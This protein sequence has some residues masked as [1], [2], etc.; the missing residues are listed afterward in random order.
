[1]ALQQHYK[2]FAQSG[3]RLL[4]SRITDAFG[5]VERA[6][7]A[8]LFD[9]QVYVD[10]VEKA[11]VRCLMLCEADASGD[12]VAFHGLPGESFEQR[13]GS[14]A[15]FFLK[16]KACVVTSRTLESLLYGELSSE[17]L[18][19]L[20]RLLAE[21]YVPVMVNPANQEGW[22]EVACKDI[23][24]KV[25][26][27]LADVTI[28]L[29]RT[30]GQTW[31]PLPP[32]SATA[33]LSADV[34]GATSRRQIG[35]GRKKE[36]VYLLETTLI[37]WTR[38]IR[39]ILRR[40]PETLLKQGYNPTPTAE[41]TFWRERASDLNAVFAQLQS[42]RVRG[43][44]AVLD[45]RR[46]PVGKS[47]R[48]LIQEVLT[49]RVE[50]IDNAKFVG[51][52]EGIFSE[53]HSAEF[54]ALPR[55]FPT[56]LYTILGIWK[57]S[58]HYN[59]HPR[60]IVL[61]N[62][63]NNE[64]I[65]KAREFAS[66]EAIFGMIDADDASLAVQK[67][68][69]I[70]RVCAAFKSTFF[71]FKSKCSE[72]CPGNA[73][74][75]P[76]NA[77][78][79]RLD[80]FVERCQD[81]LDLTQTIVQF[82]K[83]AQIEIGGTKGKTLTTSVRQI[84]ADFVDAVRAFEGAPYDI[85]DIGAKRF[86]DDFYA[87]RSR[88]KELERRLGSIITQAFDDAGTLFGQFK[89]LD[90]FESLL[91]REL[92]HDE[93]EKRHSAL[94]SSYGKDLTIVGELFSRE[95]GAFDVGA[96]TS[97]SAPIGVNLPPIAGALKWVRMLM[98]RI[99]EPMERLLQ[100]DSSIIEKEGARDVLKAFG[101]TLDR[102]Q[103]FELATMQQLN[104]VA[105]GR[106]LQKLRQP[107][108]KRNK[109]RLLT[110]NFDPALVRL[111]REVK[112]FQLE[113]LEVPHSARAIFGKVEV[114]RQQTG[115]LELIVNMYND[116]VSNMLPVERPLLHNAVREIDEQLQAGIDVL[117]W[118]S[119]GI[120]VFLSD[121]MT[122]VKSASDVLQQLKKNVVKIRT[123]LASWASEPLFVRNSKPTAWEDLK[124]DLNPRLIRRYG[125]IHKGGVR[126]HALM[127]E[128]N[129]ILRVSKGMPSWRAY[130][131]FV[132]RIVSDGLRDVAT[133]SLQYILGEIKAIKEGRKPPILEISLD[134]FGNT[135]NGIMFVPDLAAKADGTGLRDIVNEWIDGFLHVA[136][137]FPRIDEP[138][139]SV[140]A[141]SDILPEGCTVLG[142][143]TTHRIVRLA[144][145][146]SGH[147]A[148]YVKDLLSDESLHSLIGSITAE[149]DESDIACT[150]FV[151]KYRGYAYLWTTDLKTMFSEFLDDSAPLALEG[152]FVSG[153]QPQLDKFDEK[154]EYY[155][156]VQVR[157]AEL[158]TPSDVG[159]LR[160]NSQP[161]KQALN[162]CTTKWKFMF[163]NWLHNHVYDS[164]KELDAFRNFVKSGLKENPT[165]TTSLK[166][167]MTIIR[168]VRRRID[169]TQF[170]FAPLEN[171]VALLKKHG[172]VV[173]AKIGRVDV[174]E[175]LDRA[176]MK[177]ETTV[178][179]TFAKKE[180]ILPLQN[181][182]VSD[183]RSQLD[184]FAADVRSERSEFRARAPLSMAIVREVGQ[185]SST[186]GVIE[187]H[188]TAAFALLTNFDAVLSHAKEKSADLDNMC[189]L[190]EVPTQRLPELEQTAGE[191][192][193]L[194][195]V[196]TLYGE[197]AK[198]FTAWEKT[199]WGDVVT[200]SFLSK[201]QEFQE[202]L[203]AHASAAEGW[204]LYGEMNSVLEKMAIVFPLV[205]SLR[206]NAMRERHWKTLAIGCQAASL[207]TNDP[208]F[209]LR[210]LLNLQLH[211]FVDHVELVVQTATKE[212]KIEQT[213]NTI[214]A[215]WTSMTL[216]FS[217]YKD[218]GVK[219][220]SV[221]DFVLD[222]LEE[223]TAQLQMMMGMG[224]FVEYFRSRVVKWQRELSHVESVLRT[225]VQVTG[226]WQALEAIFL[227]SEEIRRQ[228]PDDASTFE[229]VHGDFASLMVQAALTPNVLKAC[230]NDELAHLL[231]AKL[232]PRLEQC[233][234]SLHH[235]L[236]HQRKKFPR[237]YFVANDALVHV[238]SNV[239]EPR[240]IV[241][242]CCECFNNTFSSIE[243]DELA[244]KQ[245]G[246]NAILSIASATETLA[247]GE[248][249]VIGADEP[250][251][252]WLARFEECITAT[253]KQQMT[254]AFKA[255][256]ELS[257]KQRFDWIFD[258]AAQI[259]LTTVETSWTEETELALINVASGSQ[260][261]MP[262]HLEK[263]QERLLEMVELA[264][265]DL[266]AAQ[267][268]T[269]VSLITADVHAR[270]VVAR[271]VE[272]EVQSKT[273][274]A[275]AQQLRF[276]WQAPTGSRKGDES[277][278]VNVQICDV[279]DQ[280]AA[281][282]DLQYLF[283][284]T[285]NNSRLVVTP[286]TERCYVT[287]TKAIS[288]NLGCMLSGPAGSGKT[289]TVK[290][291]ASALGRPMLT[292]N[293]SEQM[294]FTT[295]A[296]AF[297]GLVQNGA[298][299]CFDG[300]NRL[301]S[302]LLSVAAMQIKSVHNAIE[303]FA[304]PDARAKQYK[305]V[306]AGRPHSI[307]GE[308]ELMG[309]S[310]SLIPT[311]SF[312]ATMN[313]TYIGRT[314][315]LPASIK[316][317]FRPCGM[318]QPDILCICENMLMAQGFEEATALAV[319]FTMLYKL[320]DEMLSPQHHYDW[321]LRSAK[322]V[323]VIA[324]D[325]MRKSGGEGERLSEEAVLMRALRNANVPKLVPQDVAVFERLLKDIF[326]KSYRV[327]STQD[328]ALKSAL[329][330]VCRANVLQ[331]DT[332]FGS[333][334]LQF[335]RQLDVRR[336]VVLL[337]PAGC[338]K[339][340]VWKSLLACYN[341]GYRQPRPPMKPCAV[342]RIINPKVVSS[343]ELFGF[344][345]P[346]NV[347]ADG[348]LPT[349]MRGMAN[350]SKQL[351]FHPYQTSK[352]V[353]LDGDVDSK[354]IESM[355]SVMDDNCTLTLVSNERV[356][357]TSSMSVIFETDSLADATPATVS[358]TG[359]VYISDGDMGWQQYAD[360]WL[361]QRD[362]RKV[363]GETEME[364]LPNL[365]KTF[366]RQIVD[367]MSSK[368]FS[369]VVPISTISQVT[370]LCALLESLLPEYAAAAATAGKDQMTFDGLSTLFLFA[371]I[372][373]F[374]GAMDKNNRRR[375]H[376]AWMSVDTLRRGSSAFAH[377]AVL[378]QESQSLGEGGATI[379]DYYFD[380]V[381]GKLVPWASLVEQRYHVPIE[382]SITDV[383]AVPFFDIFVPTVESACAMYLI[384]K[385]NAQRRPVMLAGGGGS[386]KTMLL[387]EFMRRQDAGAEDRL[388]R[389]FTLNHYTDSLALQTQLQQSLDKRSGTSIG[390]PSGKSMMIFLDDLSMPS[391]DD[392]GTQS[393][394]ALVRQL[395][396]Q[397]GFYDRSNYS[398]FKTVVDTTLVAA[399]TPTAGSCT[400]KPR[401]QRHFST[402]ANAMPSSSALIAIFGSVIDGHLKH[403][404]FASSLLPR[405]VGT[406][407]MGVT[408]ASATVE[409]YS[410]MEAHFLPSATKCVYTWSMRDIARVSQGVCL[411]TAEHYRTELSFARLWLHE[412]KRVFGDRMV[413][414][415]DAT[416]FEETVVA[417]S[418][419]YFEADQEKIHA[420]P[421]TF[422]RFVTREEGDAAPTNGAEGS[423]LP[424]ARGEEG[425]SALKAALAERLASYNS[426][427][428]TTGAMN[429]VLFEE[430]MM[431]IARIVRIISASYGNALLIG[432]GGAGKQSLSR[433]AAF[434]CDFRLEQMDVSE[435]TTVEDFG[436]F[437]KRLI[438][439]SGADGVPI[440]FLLNDTQIVDERFL[441][442]IN[443]LLSMGAVDSLFDREELELLY[444]SRSF[445]LAAKES[446]VQNSPVANG[447]LFAQRVRKHLHLIFCCSPVA[448]K[449]QQRARRFPSIYAR[450]AVNWFHPWSHT[451]CVAVAQH[452]LA[453]VDIGM[454]GAQLLENVAH[455]MA[456]V[457][458][459][460]QL[461]A[462]SYAAS[463]GRH[464]H[465]TPNSFLELTK[466]YKEGLETKRG[467]MKTQIT[468]LTKAIATLESTSSSVA[469]LQKD[470]SRS[471]EELEEKRGSTDKLITEMALQRAEAEAQ[472]AAAVSERDV[473]AAAITAADALE[474]E[475]TTLSNAAEPS[476]LRAIAAVEG[477]SKQALVEF[478]NL[479][480]APAGSPTQS[481]I[482]C[483]L[484]LVEGE[485][486]THT[487][488]RVK[489][490][491]GNV[492]SF[493]AKLKD[494]CTNAAELS[495]EVTEKIAPLVAAK[496][497]EPK[498]MTSAITS[499]LCTLVQDV[500]EYSAG[501]IAARPLK[502]QLVKALLMKES[503]SANLKELDVRERQVQA[504]LDQLKESFVE[505]THEKA[506]VEAEAGHFGQRLDIASRLVSGL[507]LEKVA[508]VD[509]VEELKMRDIALVG[510]VLL[511]ASF[512]SYA[513]GFDAERREQLVQDH[514]MP[515]ML[516]NEIPLS[517]YE[518]GVSAAEEVLL[519]FTSDAELTTMRME[520]NGLS[521]QSNAIAAACRRWPL[522]VDPQRQGIAWLQKRER[523][524][525][526]LSLELAADGFWA[527]LA[528]AVRA[529]RPTL[530]HNLSDTI[531]VGLRPLIARAVYTRGTQL[532]LRIAGK[533]VEYNPSFRLFL[534]T[535]LPKPHF[536]PEIQAQCTLVNFIATD[537]GLEEQ[538]LARVVAREQPE[539]EMKKSELAAEVVQY[540]SR[541]G[542]C[543]CVCA[544]V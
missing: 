269:V 451:S 284:Y 192:T 491:M 339:S 291:L 387:R 302:E 473:A 35:G 9:S 256:A 462:S 224:R 287:L 364:V 247:F 501:C 214:E 273:D 125:E 480:K 250:V 376:E 180:E 209:C 417:A 497:F 148:S 196:W 179:I 29:G 403:N 453:D 267:R 210:D 392:T 271:L 483:L 121:T 22:G 528:T 523:A 539:L 515:D 437:L 340:T 242:E 442:Y 486:R 10:F 521:P 281:G 74:L 322:A 420:K 225:W 116:I 511:G 464:V 372:W 55:S 232:L 361:E 406:R 172:E 115:N 129:K 165:D 418:K 416:R 409:L 53:M 135:E 328:D 42:E 43:V 54:E 117:N 386:G 268:V 345:R 39:E 31:L 493:L 366:V 519:T 199:L 15:V 18:A 140:I 263:R 383:G 122:K 314:V 7:V 467:E 391:A 113:G 19:H 238:L 78:F 257:D 342:A 56:L 50:A 166:R 499:T 265:Q 161:I 507:D 41:L 173:N 317:H 509:E 272:Q 357:L 204:I 133:T 64:I 309:D 201:V 182:A 96:A 81:V 508:W 293:C 100:L 226:Q 290:D 513:G 80:S 394:L 349:V 283:Q 475:Y 529:G 325:V 538:L 490:M 445:R 98:Q 367:T 86:D 379:F 477:L 424:L 156:K 51:M 240:A 351:G 378:T 463:Q 452:F 421:L 136:T 411:S 474:A 90:S 208:T 254:D 425:R 119:H 465:V 221:S 79:M 286:L 94:V 207:A 492:N 295:M 93:L 146:P 316:A 320:G 326:P 118:K 517:E 73:W 446:G 396:D 522:L 310:V 231:S 468:R 350:N 540:V 137:L 259:V 439:L 460:S 504:Q 470:V 174:L 91:E 99:R 253:L 191:L 315:V 202:A 458:H 216:E 103:Q 410:K 500:L 49:A 89:L 299:G 65:E 337:G 243:F 307:V 48:K 128:S 395:F 198:T 336:S 241:A 222:K 92:I 5:H 535:R 476:L 407:T 58:E 341:Q 414:S 303:T 298:W 153:R 237:F 362:R 335:Q 233:Q 130:V 175:Y 288:M 60:L 363:A 211:K 12:I 400:I 189:D 219:L 353:V 354:W 168:D 488:A 487:W 230:S 423:Y 471:L 213:L 38:L 266:T 292:F 358:R 47:F 1:M 248:P 105:D 356:E 390:P 330:S 506:K 498:E 412:A 503:A 8:E 313:P 402:I 432:L 270:D 141:A 332:T 459:S 206:T 27:L 120:D 300:I 59:T 428:T 155:S 3:V 4:R 393:A 448:E 502:E 143:S 163:T 536:L 297:K 14:K 21:V 157:V 245:K 205:E 169:A 178:N 323:L 71:D 185:R 495:D 360:S 114:Y 399:L 97:A 160:I 472:Q 197:I 456:V 227:R 17:P 124:A 441:V 255:G 277:A 61:V 62:E 177:W 408:L 2:M 524:N 111:L 331:N 107:L 162:T 34:D 45:A 388:G 338:G 244:F 343:D 134:L 371:C 33:A 235:Y 142:S 218:T 139:I 239:T 171:C 275:W 150:E 112:Y 466:F 380:V 401:V 40:D 144:G 149:M 334:V 527:Q 461:V 151:R 381:E 278:R 132:N 229:Q 6:H 251:H 365:F 485:M 296:V 344:M 377:I 167:I 188:A 444:Q 312:F 258:F 203:Q 484:V 25:Y 308:F 67:L 44:L 187:A 327:R 236:A 76:N 30:R 280:A 438:E 260:D 329:K 102:L 72:Q 234:R 449:F 36:Q 282:G 478:K 82:G 443:D 436:A 70:L 346:N 352:W 109:R 516:S 26:R 534:Q 252:E 20:R 68:K 318:V 505:A 11:E 530:I 195:A 427:N 542:A 101:A 212:L 85:M 24:D 176:P 106:S 359:I 170:L 518:D 541:V 186:T 434:I 183:L 544:C 433:L 510:D 279:G 264:R 520:T 152:D 489:K 397:G 454:G 457:H 440:A 294:T 95:R 435:T 46:V 496:D 355:N 512:I 324:G 131:A 190:F 469:D 304:D 431:H 385:L 543:V 482:V 525:N 319:K 398:E 285:G 63:V 370:T 289:E 404:N 69:A 200:A 57:R 479:T 75:I 52:L 37:H 181:K 430:A 16:Q 375:F 193:Q 389:M 126:M 138:D 419:C 104:K 415:A 228:L 83:L 274:F 426:E 382:Q 217:L 455:H 127:A 429:L 333:K 301:S 215:I 145:V 13:S 533:E 84:Y 405:G 261:A 164:L 249:F 276:Y 223:H 262:A 306:A 537:Q 23:M 531:D 305:S 66:G 28:T 108:L 384:G 347:W 348:L 159:W 77:L 450:S 87:F 154:I 321:S 532:Y 246:T 158:E 481:L 373:A 220:V 32:A 147:S 526:L 374:G 184:T 514:W 413:T 194:H 311:T 447:E 368:M 369:T 110:V 422:T 494:A 88:T 123:D